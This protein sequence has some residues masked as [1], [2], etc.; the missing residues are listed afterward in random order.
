MPRAKWLHSLLLTSTFQSVYRR[1]VSINFMSNLLPSWMFFMKDI[2]VSNCAFKA[3]ILTYSDDLP[4]ETK[5]QVRLAVNQIL[6]TDV[7]DVTTDGRGG[8]EHKC[9]IL[10]D[11]VHV[12]LLLVDGTLVNCVLD[13]RVDQLAVRQGVK[14]KKLKTIFWQLSK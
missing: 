14:G 1:E 11:G 10:M 3:V 2:S 8:V 12:Q 4:D 5:Y 13:G 6:G 9:L 7:D